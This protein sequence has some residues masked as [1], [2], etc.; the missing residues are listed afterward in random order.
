MKV[1]IVGRTKMAGSSRC[2]GGLLA[3]CTSVRLV[4]PGGQWDTTS[5]FDVGDVWN[6][7]FQNLANLSPPHTEDILV[8]KYNYVEEQTDLR[9]N[10]LGRLSPWEGGIDK[11]FEGMLGFTGNNNGFISRERGVPGYSTWFWIPDTDLILRDD[12]KHYDYQQWFGRKGMSYVGEPT[13]IPIIPAGTLVRLSL[14]RWW[15][16]DDVEDLEERC[17]LQL[18]GWF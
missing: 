11:V 17:Y 5:Q 13:P 7:D 14:A 6:I 16:P 8:T 4:K 3:D 15:K 9:D 18:S 10:L 2:I 1:L 12:G